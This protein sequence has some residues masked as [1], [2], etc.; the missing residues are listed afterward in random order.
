MVGK[1]EICG[2]GDG[3]MLCFNSSYHL[4]GR[5]VIIATAR[6]DRGGVP[7]PAYKNSAGKKSERFPPVRSLDGLLALILQLGAA[8]DGGDINDLVVP[9]LLVLQLER[10]ECRPR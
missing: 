8:A 7:F 3:C 9:L 2:G 1:R 5:I 6:G 10:V 4:T